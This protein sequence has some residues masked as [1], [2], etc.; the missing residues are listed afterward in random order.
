MNVITTFR[1]KQYKKRITFERKVLRELSLNGLKTEFNKLFFPFFQYSLL[2]QDEIQDTSIDIAI[3]AY[4]LGAEFSR[5]G[6]HGESIESIKQRSEQAEKRLSDTLFEYWQ[7][8]SYAPDQI[9]ESLHMCCEAFV[10]R[11]WSEGF[12]KG[13]RRYKMRLH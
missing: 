13:Q 1:E 4:L 10:Q 11:W 5:F 8:W 6:Y 7:F 2:F 9:L 12:E 3:E